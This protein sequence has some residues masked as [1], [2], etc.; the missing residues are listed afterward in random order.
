MK[1]AD[2]SELLGI[3]HLDSSLDEVAGALVGSLLGTGELVDPARRMLEAGGKRLRPLLTIASAVA[4]QP[5]VELRP[6]DARVRRGAA[7]VELVHVGSLVHDDIMDEAFSRRGVP[8]VNAVEGSNQALL[9]GDFLLARAGVEAAYV[10]AE[11]ALSLAVTI[12]DLCDGQSLE[13]LHQFRANRSVDDAIES[14]KG[15]TG[16]L[17]RAACD[18]GALCVGRLDL[19]DAFGSFGMNFGISFQLVDDLLD[20]LSTAELM[21]KPVNND[22]RAGV[23]TVPM[24]LTV[25]AA[26]GSDRERLVD[27]MLAA[28]N[29][30]DAADE[31]REHVLA[32]SAV[33]TTM[34]LIEHYNA[35]ARE[36]LSVVAPGKTRDGLIEV[37]Q[38]YLDGILAEKVP[39]NLR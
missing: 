5:S 15:K 32:G 39:A 34:G 29:S 6:L 12:S 3:E 20:L 13:G 28:A 4:S 37:P 11:V 9:V 2:F 22:V 24:L 26:E 23:F 7:S 19:A 38:R 33:A 16:A 21:G 10:S 25:H 31:F 18:I 30:A 36:A 1:A 17:M 8:T 27:L 14:I 35:L